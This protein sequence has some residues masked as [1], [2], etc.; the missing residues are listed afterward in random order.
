MKSVSLIVSI[1]LIVLNI[2]AGLMLEAYHQENVIMSTCVLAINALLLWVIAHCDMKD[3][4]KVSY[5]ILFPLFCLVE[6]ILAIV[7]PSQWQNNYYL[8]G[9]ICCLAVQVVLFF[10]ALKTSR[11]NK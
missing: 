7:A 8:I 1:I 2:L 6:L 10:T 9:I 11:H 3:A 5:H 4:F